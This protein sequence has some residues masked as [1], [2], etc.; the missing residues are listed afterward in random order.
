MKKLLKSFETVALYLSECP[1]NKGQTRGQLPHCL[2]LNSPDKQN[3]G[4]SA[5]KA[6]FVVCLSKRLPYIGLLNIG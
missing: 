1:K 3:K 5:G 2:T 4:V 6:V